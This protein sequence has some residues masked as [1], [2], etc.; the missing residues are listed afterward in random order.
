MEIAAIFNLPLK[1]LD[2]FILEQ[3]LI[4]SEQKINESKT[5]FSFEIENLNACK[6]FATC[7]IPIIEI[8]PSTLFM[9]CRLAKVDGRPINLIVDTTNYIM[10]DISQPM[11]AFDANKIHSG[12]MGPRFAKNGEKITLLDNE[13]IELT[14]K[15]LIIADTQK[16]IA[17]AGIMGGINSEVDN[18]TT[19]LLIE[20]ANFDAA[21]IRKTST[22]I[23]KRTDASARFEKTL[24]L[25]QNVIAIERFIQILSTNNIK[26]SKKTIHSLGIRND[27]KIIE[28]SHDF[29]ENKLGTKTTEKFIIETLEKLEFIVKKID[30]NKIIYEITIPSFR[31]TKDITIPEDIVEEIG[32]FFGYGNI[33]FVLP[34]KQI[35][36][37][38]LEETRRLRKIKQYLAF[39]ANMHEVQNYPFYDETFIKELNWQP[40]NSTTVTNPV[41]EN[42]QRLINSL[43]P[44]L[45]KNVQQNLLNPQKL[46]FFEINNIWDTVSSTETIET[47]SLAGIFFDKKKPI[48]FYECKAHLENLFVS[49]GFDIKWVKNKNNTNPWFSDYQTAELFYENKKIGLAGMISQSFFSQIC[50]GDAF[51]FEIDANFLLKTKTPEMRF[52]VISKY[53]SVWLDISLL[54]PLSTTVS[55]VSDIIE[56]SDTKIY[57]TEIVDYFENPNW[58]DKKSIT[59]R[60]H[61]VDEYKTLSKEEIDEVMNK[62]IENVKKIDAQIR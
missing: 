43:I 23:K 7:Y 32:R 54:V 59:M 38:D 58:V 12:K 6:K 41:S 37:F 39:S 51:I 19:A 31:A 25:D 48:D 33:K 34:A 20:S 50:D 17:L 44:H 40:A 30:V 53:P 10:L 61:L 13:T 5:P 18:N 42:W 28:I 14:N 46:Q 8:K 22:T 15:D 3:D 62:V 56:K 4:E 26:I 1:P 11:H 47:K 24:D 9:A 55:Q 45:L 2:H 29:I 49:L 36:P 16:P 52:K 35:K 21:T 57:K 60:Y 27:P